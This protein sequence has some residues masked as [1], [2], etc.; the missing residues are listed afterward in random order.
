MLILGP[1]L[2]NSD[3]ED[4]IL[5]DE[6]D[7]IKRGEPIPGEAK[8][9]R[10]EYERKRRENLT[11]A[12]EDLKNV[13]VTHYGAKNLYS[14][15][16]IVKE[17]TS[18]LL[19]LKDKAVDPKQNQLMRN[20]TEIPGLKKLITYVEELRSKAADSPSPSGNSDLPDGESST[21]RPAQPVYPLQPSFPIDAQ[22]Y[23]QSGYHIAPN[24]SNKDR[25]QSGYSIPTTPDPAVL[26]QMLQNP[27]FLQT[28]L[29]SHLMLNKANEKLFLD[30]P[31]QA[32]PAQNTRIQQQ[33]SASTQPSWQVPQQTNMANA[34]QVQ[35][36]SNTSQTVNSNSPTRNQNNN[37]N[38]SNMNNGNG[39]GNGQY[40]NPQGVVEYSRFLMGIFVFVGLFHQ[41][42]NFLSFGDSHT[43]SH[44]SS[45]SLQSMDAHLTSHA[46]TWSARLTYYLWIILAFIQF[47][48]QSS[49]VT[50][51]CYLLLLYCILGATIGS[52]YPTLN[53]RIWK[54]VNKLE[55]IADEMEDPTQR[56]EVLTEA[57]ILTGGKWPASNID[58]GLYCIWHALRIIAQTFYVGLLAEKMT[59]RQASKPVL[60]KR[61][62]LLSKLA[63][64]KSR[65]SLS[66]LE[67]WYCTLKQASSIR[68]LDK[69]QRATL[70]N[71]NL[72]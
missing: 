68:L 58:A 6:D 33:N 36:S 40:D 38:G 3:D 21:S 37:P 42:Y 62:Q 31:Q 24:Y 53:T 10:K 57:F 1:R 16:A 22:V 35:Y 25:D 27:Y 49:Q 52:R 18:C 69:E 23:R 55:K 51:L 12:F 14:R 7:D 67:Q 13:L 45:R 64:P 34:Y 60:C 65:N 66:R 54:R 47:A 17:A 28:A 30:P 29:P 70:A 46:N 56:K 39:N 4:G 19:L 5:S 20:I 9:K 2:D 63:A 44:S 15:S 43:V 50:L 59:T 8:E 61:F 41:A 11:S 72:V 48:S 32:N 26:N 71:V